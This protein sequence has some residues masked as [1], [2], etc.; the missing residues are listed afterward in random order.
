[1]NVQNNDFFRAL[2]EQSGQTPR[3][4]WHTDP[5]DDEPKPEPQTLASKMFPKEARGLVFGLIGLFGLVVIALLAAI[6]S[7]SVISFRIKSQKDADKAAAAAQPAATLAANATPSAPLTMPAS[8]MPALT[9]NPAAMEKLRKDLKSATA[10]AP[11]PTPLTVI[12]TPVSPNKTESQT[13]PDAQAQPKEAAK[14]QALAPLAPLPGASKPA[15]ASIAAPAAKTTSDSTL[16]MVMHA[17]SLIREGQISSARL[18]LQQAS[19]SGD[20]QVYFAL[21]ETYDPLALQRW[22]A[23]GISGDKAK[24][25]DL[26]QKAADAGSPDAA[27]RINA[28][29][30]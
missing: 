18:L 29:K 1:M 13:P 27:D 23:I 12:A 8:L 22:N 9:A 25:L 11:M 16:N 4:P 15:P 30:K 28:L 24:A 7:D 6:V 19:Q 20:A 14:V 21:A 3:A 10:P 2:N 5:R 26:Y 17:A